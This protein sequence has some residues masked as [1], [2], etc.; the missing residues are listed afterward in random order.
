MKLVMALI[1]SLFATAAMA[2]PRQGDIDQKALEI[3]IK[4]SGKMQSQDGQS[5][6]A[7]LAQSL[8]TGDSTHNKINNDC[9]L[10]NK[11]FKCTLIIANSDDDG[12]TESSMS[13]SYV[14]DQDP[15]GL[16]SEKV[17]QWTFEFF[18]AG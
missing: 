7:L 6:A 15:S 9:K 2:A 5:G 8:T 14:L 16:P 4:N 12:Q 17:R 1:L 11:T 3:F 10:S 18:L 13:F